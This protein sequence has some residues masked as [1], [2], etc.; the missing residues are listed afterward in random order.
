MTPTCMTPAAKA[1]ARANHGVGTNEGSSF[2]N[3][4][5]DKLL[6]SL[7]L[8][9]T[10]STVGAANWIDMSTSVLGASVVSAFLG[11]LNRRRKLL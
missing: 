3:V 4:T 8:G 9:Y 5:N 11:L 7:I 2:N 10:S 1:M 6:D